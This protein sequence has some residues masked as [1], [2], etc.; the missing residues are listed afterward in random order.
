[1]NTLSWKSCQGSSL[2]LPD[3]RISRWRNY[4]I[5][6]E[7]SMPHAHTISSRI[8]SRHQSRLEES[9]EHSRFTS[10]HSD[11]QYLPLRS[12]LREI[13]SLQVMLKV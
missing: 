6:A 10:T 4:H 7:S 5:P 11:K 12:M 13:V 9:S 3:H 2:N 1:S 8:Y